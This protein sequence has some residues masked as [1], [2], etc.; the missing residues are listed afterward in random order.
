MIKMKAIKKE[1][2]YGCCGRKKNENYIQGEARPGMAWL[3]KAKQ[4]GLLVPIK[5]NNIKYK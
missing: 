4:G 3:G 5:T 1:K 2:V